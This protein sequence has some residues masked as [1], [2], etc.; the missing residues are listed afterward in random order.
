MAA[1]EKLEKCPFFNERMAAMPSITR[2]LKES[3]CL[4]AK[5]ACARYQVSQAGKPVPETLFP[6][7]TAK[8]AA[9]LGR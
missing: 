8:V 9:L 2:N 7:E 5:E 1:C 6:H 4:S 3:Y